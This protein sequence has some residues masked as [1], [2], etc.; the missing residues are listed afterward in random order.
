MLKITFLVFTLTAWSL[1]V[2]GQNS[3]INGSTLLITNVTVINIDEPPRE[4]MTVT[5]TGRHIVSV[6]PN[7]KKARIPKGSKVIDGTGKF[8]I[9]GLWDMHAHLGDENFDK[10][11]SSGRRLV[12]C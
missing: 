5:I 2:A 6:L 1:L 11:N 10:S 4:N 8:L 3:L 7:N 9:P 12:S